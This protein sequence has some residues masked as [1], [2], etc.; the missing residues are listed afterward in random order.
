MTAPNLPPGFDPGVWQ[1]WWLDAV[2]RSHIQGALGTITCCRFALGMASG[3][4][5]SAYLTTRTLT[6]NP[7]K[8]PTISARK[9]AAEHGGWQA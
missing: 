3:T 4:F 5:R 8:P 9:Y 2:P 6:K 1:G 7:N